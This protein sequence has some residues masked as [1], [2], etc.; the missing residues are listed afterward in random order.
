M[1]TAKPRVQ[2]TLSATA[3]ESLSRV[4]RARRVSRS[5]V[6]AELLEAARPALDRVAELIEVSRAAPKEVLQRFASA[7]ELNELQQTGAITSG[8]GQLDLLIHGIK[9]GKP[10]DSFTPP[11]EVRPSDRAQRDADRTPPPRKASRTPVPVTR[12]STHRV[13]PRLSRPL[14]RVSRGKSASKKGRLHK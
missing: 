6:I 12:G 4:S 7:V 2:V 10:W 11:E 9:Q 13:A 3:Y 14:S 8:L 1:P 5:A